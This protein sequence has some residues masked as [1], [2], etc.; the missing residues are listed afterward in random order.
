MEGFAFAVA[1][2]R[3]ASST[4]RQQGMPFEVQ[5]HQCSCHGNVGVY[6]GLANNTD[7]SF[8]ARTA[9]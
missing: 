2:A 8:D 1:S 6:R 4:N 5:T 9:G 3:A 7:A